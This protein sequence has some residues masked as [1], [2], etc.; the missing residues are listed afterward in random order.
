M[1]RE[2][3]RER[4]MDLRSKGGSV[5]GGRRRFPTALAGIRL[6]KQKREVSG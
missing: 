6:N 2:E 5:R 1:V 3:G 4:M